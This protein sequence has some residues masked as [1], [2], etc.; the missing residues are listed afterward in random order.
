MPAL[1]LMTGHA[2]SQ[3]LDDGTSRSRPMMHAAALLTPVLIVAASLGLLYIYFYMPIYKHG[4]LLPMTLWLLAAGGFAFYCFVKKKA[5]PGLAIL[6]VAV[7]TLEFWF[8]GQGMRLAER[9]RTLIEFARYATTE[10]KG[11]SGDKIALFQYGTASLIFY[12]NPSSNTGNVNNVAEMEAFRKKHPD[13]Y[14]IADLNEVHGAENIAYMN[15]LKAVAVQNTE[16][17]EMAERFVLFK[18]P[19]ESP[20]PPNGTRP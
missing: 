7:M 13:G 5:K 9:K 18:F 10:L 19:Q 11:V 3:W 16:T 8:F 14:I 12:L 6:I 1:A 2:L 20:A 15:R 4:S 17:N